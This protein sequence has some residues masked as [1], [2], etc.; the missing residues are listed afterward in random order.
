MWTHTLR[1]TDNDPIQSLVAHSALLR[2]AGKCARIRQSVLAQDKKHRS[3]NGG[4][5]PMKSRVIFENQHYTACAMRDGSLIV[6][7][8]RKQ[9][10]KRL[11]GDKVAEWIDAIT[12]ALDASEANDLCRVFLQ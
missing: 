3:D 11:T 7:H 6:T 1:V 4:E 12:N 2:F 8:K 5:E 10:G 9:G